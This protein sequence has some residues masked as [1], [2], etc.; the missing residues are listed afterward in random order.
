MT[1]KYYQLRSLLLEYLIE[2]LKDEDINSNFTKRVFLCG[3]KDFF[4]NH[5]DTY[6]LEALSSLI[7]YEIQDPR[8]VEKTDKELMFAL[9]IASDLTFYLKND[10]KRH[11]ENLDQIKK[12]YEENKTFLE[13]SHF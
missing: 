3:L 7:L 10:K 11:K 2:G 13:N 9:D 1:D 5:I 4:E 6:E 12:Y 8:K